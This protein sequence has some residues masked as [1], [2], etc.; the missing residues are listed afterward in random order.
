MK[1]SNTRKLVMTGMF[2]AIAYILFFIQFAVPFMP[3]FIKMDISELPALIGAFALGPV[4]GVIICLVKN[5]IHLLQTSTGGVGE[6]SNFLLGAF[7]VFPAGMIYKH[8]KSR[9]SAIIGCLVG[10][11]FMAIGS[12]VTN[13]FLV[14][15]IYTKFMPMDAIIEAY[16]AINPKVDSLM[17]CLV[18]FNMP[19]TFVKGMLSVVVTLLVYKRL[20]PI[21][22]GNSGI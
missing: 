1:N 21:I 16:K 4:E 8:N 17:A 12:I 13:Y 10:A 14:Y 19:F 5:V 20:S 18:M 7:F 2:S 3:G 11:V 22:K 15:P 6:L 9:K